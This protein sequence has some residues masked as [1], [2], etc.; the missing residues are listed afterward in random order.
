MGDELRQPHDERGAGDPGHH[1]QRGT[2]GVVVG[3]ML[4]P[5]EPDR[6]EQALLAVAERDHETRR[7][8]QRE[9]DGDVAGPLGDLLLPALALLLP[10]LELRDDDAEQLHDDRAVMYGMIPRKNTDDARDRAAR[11]QVEEADR[12][13]ELVDWSWSALICAKS[14]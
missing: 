7:L 3:I 12:R 6:A 1:D 10:L 11:E 4:R 13:P 5:C 14:T 2:V 8:Q 9:T